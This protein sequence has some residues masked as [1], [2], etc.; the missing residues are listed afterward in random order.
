[1]KSIF[2]LLPALIAFTT[3]SSAQTR[4]TLIVTQPTAV[5][6][7]GGAPG[8]LTVRRSGGT[9]DSLRVFYRVAGSARNGVDYQRL[10][11]SVEIP[12]GSNQA[13]IEIIPRDDA[14][15]EPTERV[16]VQL[17]LAPR[18]SPQYRLGARRSQ[19]IQILDNDQPVVIGRPPVLGLPTWFPIPGIVTTNTPPDTN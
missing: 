12:A 4:V 8:V 16:A 14:L 1:M 9:E 3:A 5:E 6:G 19:A 2:L 13:T 11:G 15:R 7:Q 18:N 17:R 10:S